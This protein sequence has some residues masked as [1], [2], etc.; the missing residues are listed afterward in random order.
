MAR[1]PQTRSATLR[2]RD[3]THLED[4]WDEPAPCAAPACNGEPLQG[5]WLCVSGRR[6]G[7]LLIRGG[8]LTLHFADGTIYMGTVA[9]GRN[10]RV[11]TMDVRV[12]EGPPRHK[13][14]TALCIYELNGDTLLWCTASPGQAD[15]PIAFAEYDP[16]HL[17]LTFQRERIDCKQ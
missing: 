13:G 9:L 3:L 10:G 14:Q 2:D 15:R 11:G 7:K 4:L 12:E 6:P 5:A 8:H 17:F 16:Q 1:T